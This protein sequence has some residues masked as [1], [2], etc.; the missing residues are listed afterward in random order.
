MGLHILLRDAALDA[1]SLDPA[2]IG[3]ELA[4]ELAHRRAG[5]GFRECCFVD[6][7]VGARGRGCGGHRIAGDRRRRCGRRNRRPGLS[8]PGR[9]RCTGALEP[10]DGAAGRA[11]RLG[12]RRLERQDQRALGH[13]IAL[14]E[15]DL[16]DA[17]GHRRRH[18][19]CRLF[20]FERDQR[21]FFLDLLTV[22]DQDV[23]DI[24]VLKPPMSEPELRLE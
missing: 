19:H 23:D 2:Q 3:A 14:F 9:R 8:R 1:G 15:F 5:V 22:L 4:R 24:D 10:G 21:R 18:V 7:G 12:R 17:A 6:H 13:F 16:R 11:A 20:R